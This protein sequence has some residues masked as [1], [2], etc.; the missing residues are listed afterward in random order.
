MSYEHYRNLMPL[1]YPNAAGSDDED[2][3][4]L[5]QASSA[6]SIPYL[7]SEQK[8]PR[9]EM[10]DMRQR[11]EEGSI[12]LSEIKEDQGLNEAPSSW[13]SGDGGIP[14]DDS[15]A[16]SLQFML[17]EDPEASS[18]RAPSRLLEAIGRDLALPIMPRGRESAMEAAGLAAEPTVAAPSHADQLQQLADLI[19]ANNA[20]CEDD[21]PLFLRRARA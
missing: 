18:G 3:H 2:L 17:D 6:G 19:A 7:P 9:R 10:Q 11:L 20:S 13:P 8:R 14:R 21:V 12:C 15:K 16:R 1:P 5:R 4:Q